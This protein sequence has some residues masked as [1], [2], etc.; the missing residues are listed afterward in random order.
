M[1]WIKRSLREACHVCLVFVMMAGFTDVGGGD[2]VFTGSEEDK[3]NSANEPNIS[4][5][6]AITLY[7]S[8]LF[9]WSP[10]PSGEV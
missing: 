1:G 8:A 9:R 10:L 6:Q 7:P 4:R 5:K 3:Q 2:G